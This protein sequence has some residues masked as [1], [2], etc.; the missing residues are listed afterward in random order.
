MYLLWASL[1]QEGVTEVS[2][3]STA[4]KNSSSMVCLTAHFNRTN[5]CRWRLRS[6]LS[7]LLSF[8]ILKQT[9]RKAH[10]FN[11]L[12]SIQTVFRQS[13]VTRSFWRH[14]IA[15]G[16]FF[17]PYFSS[18]QFEWAE[19]EF[20]I[21]SVHLY[22]TL[23]VGSQGTCLRVHMELLLRCKEINAELLLQG[24]WPDPPE[25]SPTLTFFQKPEDPKDEKHRELPTPCDRSV[26]LYLMM[27]RF[28]WCF[29]ILLNNPNSIVTLNPYLYYVLNIKHYIIDFIPILLSKIQNHFKKMTKLRRLAFVLYP[30]A[31]KP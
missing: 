16:G 1:L 5:S 20:R 12:S 7:F 28:M 13:Y 23:S 15:F 27:L 18:R 14:R 21:Q 2:P 10:H 24:L 11:F 9:S 25:A 17:L 4:P 22:K 31:G 6:L 30:C 8:S 29:V 19:P 3:V 26:V